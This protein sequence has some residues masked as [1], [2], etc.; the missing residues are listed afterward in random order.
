MKYLVFFVLLSMV[1]FVSFA[2]QKIT[3]VRG[4]SNYF[5]MEFVE[6]GKLKGLHIEVIKA[7]A[8]TLNIEVEFISLPWKRGLHE[9][10]KGNYDAMS[11]V[12]KTEER[13]SFALFL[14][15]NIISSSKTYPII[16]AERKPEIFYDGT[17]LSLAP[18][19]IAVGNGYKYGEPFDSADYFSKYVVP[20]P[21]QLVLTELLLKRRVDIIIGS[22][23]NLRQVYTNEQIEQQFFIFPAAVASAHSYLAFSKVRNKLPQAT[24]FANGV[25]LFKMTQQYKK[26]VER[27]SDLKQVN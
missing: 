27:Y 18:Y 13:E 24:E 25:A 19:T 17:L 9:F 20:T 11:Y 2:S 23:R 10:E 5:P 6:E 16:L 8:D 15:G 1:S 3:I 12:S 21:S 7:V 22:K 26:L 4:D 14:E